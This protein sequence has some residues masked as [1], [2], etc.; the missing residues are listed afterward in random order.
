MSEPGKPPDF[1]NLTENLSQQQAKISALKEL[2]RQSESQHGKNTASAQE[3]VKNIAQRLSSLKTKAA[4]S[5]HRSS[6]DLSEE[7]GITNIEEEEPA[8]LDNSLNMSAQSTSQRARS[9]TPGTEK[10]T[11]LRKQMELNRLK[12]AERETKSKEIEQMVTQLKSKFE[13]SQMSLEKSVELGRSMGDLSSMSLLPQHSQS[14]SDVSHSTRSFNLEN[15][16]IKYLERR[17]REL[18]S[19][20]SENKNLTESERVHRLE[21][22]ILDLEENL[23][24]KE[25]IIEARTKAVSLLSENLTKKKKDVVDSLEDTKQEMFKMQETFLDTETTYKDEVER[26]NR[27][28]SEQS[29]EIQNLTEKCEILEK[30]RYDLTIENSKWNTQL[31]DVQDYSTKI[32]ELNKLNETLQKQISNLESQRYEFVNEEDVDDSAA[33][34]KGQSRADLDEKIKSLEELVQSKSDEIDQ[35]KENLQE[36]STELEVV[37][38]NFSVLQDKYNSLGPKSLFP[39]DEAVDEEAQAEI[40]K[41]KQQLDDSN[42]N[43]IKTKLKVKQLEKQVNSFKKADG[44]KE[45]AKLTE[46]IQTLTQRIAELEEDKSGNQWQEWGNENDSELEKKIKVLETTCQNQTSAIQLLE[47]QKMDIT[48]DLQTAKQELGTSKEN[49]ELQERLKSLEELNE[50]LKRQIQELDE[51]KGSTENKLKQYISENIELTERIDKLSKGSSAESIEMVTLSAKDNEEYQKA[52]GGQKEHHD[53]A[54]PEISQELNDSLRNLREESSELMSKIEL[55]TIERREVLDKLDALSIENQVLVSSIESLRDEKVALEHENEALKEKVEQFERLL[56]ELQ[57]DKEEL[58][59]KASDLN[60]HRS[61][62]Q[63][64]IN[65]L[66][67]EGLESSPHGSPS[68][69]TV[70]DTDTPTESTPAIDR[71][72]C[73]KL[74]KQLDAEIQNLNKNKDK[75]QK[76]KIS[77]KLSENAKSVHA[78][79]TNLLVSYFKSLDD[80]KQLRDDLEK[81]K[82]LMSNV[83]SS[84]KEEEELRS[85]LQKLKETDNELSQRNVECK[86]LQSRLDHLEALDQ[87]TANEEISKLKSKLQELNEDADDKEKL[88]S[89]LQEMIETLTSERDRYEIEVQNQRTLVDDLRKEFDQLCVDVKVNN[90]RLNEKSSEL[91]QLQRE[92]DMRLKTSTNEVEVLKTLVA[93][94]KQLLIDSYQEHELD[95][96]QKIKEINDYQNQIKQMEDELNSLRKLNESNQESYSRDLNSEVVKLKKLLEENNQ[97]LE[98]HKEE[99]LHKQETIDSLNNQII[100]LYKTM[101]ENSSK[102]IEK[103]DEIQY[104]Q[105]ISESSREEIRK[106]HEKLSQGTKTIDDLRAQLSDCSRENELLQQKSAVP[107]N[108][109]QAELRVKK[110]ETDI[111]SLEVKNK[112]QLDKLKKFAANLKKKQ[113]QCTELEAKLAAG[114]NTNTTDAMITNELKAKVIQYE[115][116]LNLIKVE[117]SK[118]NNSLQKS[119]VVSNDELN[120]LRQKIDQYE[121]LTNQNAQEISNLQQQLEDSLA[122]CDQMEEALFNNQSQIQKLETEKMKLSESSNALGEVSQKLASIQRERDEL[123]AKI[124][125]HES[126]DKAEEKKKKDK[127]KAA[128]VQLKHKLAEKKKEVEE[129]TKQLEELKSSSS[130]NTSQSTELLEAQMKEL[131]EMSGKIIEETKSAYEHDIGMLRQQIAELDANNRLLYED[132]HRKVS[133]EGQL[134][135]FEM[136]NARLSEKV[137]KLEETLSS[138]ES[139][140]NSLLREKLS[141]A[142]ELEEKDELIGQKLRETESENF[143]LSETIKELTAERNSLLQKFTSVESQLSNSYEANIEKLTNLEGDN[144]QLRQQIE[145]LQG[146]MKKLQASHEQAVAAKHAEIDEMEADLSSQ[147]QRIEADKKSIQEAL[148]KANDQIVDFQ[149]EVVRLKDNSHTLEQARSDLERELSWLRLQSENYTQ[150]QLENEQLRMQLMQSETETENL[151][152]QNENIQENHAVEI[153]ILKQQI[154]DLEA[155][156]SQVSQNQT[157]DQVMLHNE[158]VKL[159]ELLA[160]KENVIQHKT[161]Q[162][163]M[164]STFDAPVQAVNDPFANLMSQ[165]SAPPQT[166]SDELSVLKEKLQQAEAEIAKLSEAKVMS[167]MELDVQA[168]KLQD[169]LEENRHLRDKVIEMQ[170][171]MDNLIRTNVALEESF[172]RQKHDV[173]EPPVTSSVTAAPAPFGTSML[174]SDEAAQNTAASLFDDPFAMN[175]PPQEVVEEIIKPKKAYLCYDKNSTVETQTDEDWLTDLQEKVT[176]I[177]NLQLHIQSMEQRFVDV[178]AE[179]AMQT[180]S[181]QTHMQRIQELELTLQQQAVT[182]QVLSVAQYFE[183]AQPTPQNVVP[184]SFDQSSS[185]AALEIEDGWGWGATENSEVQQQHSQQQM[186]LLSPRSDL[187][188]RLQEQRDIVDRLEQEKNSLSEELSN[189]RDNSKKMMKKLKEY[190]TKVKDLETRALRKSSSVESNDMDLVIQE[191]LNSQV[192]KLEGKLKDLN[193]EREKEQQE[194]EALAKRVDVL[195]AANERMIEGKERQDNQL[196][197]YQL[198][199]RDLNQKLHNLEEWGEDDEKKNQPVQ[200]SST[201]ENQSE[202]QKVIE[203]LNAQIKD[204]QVDF[205]E[206][207][208]LLDDEKSNSKILEEKVAK[209]STN[210]QE[211]SFKDDEIERL[212]QLLKVNLLQKDHL[213]QEVAI[214]DREIQDLISKLDLLSNES[215]NIRTILDDLSTQIQLKTNEN[216]ELNERLQK[217][218]TNNDDLSRERQLFNDSMEQNY[219]QHANDLE[220][221]LQ[222]LHAEL[223]YKNSQI[224][225]L[226]GKVSSLSIESDQAQSIIDSSNLRDQELITLRS[227]VQELDSLRI[228]IQELETQLQVP[229]SPQSSSEDIN[230]RLQELEKLN[231]NWLLEKSQMEHELQV[232]NDQVL[233][234]LEFEDKMKNTVLE[235][236]SKNIEIQVLK[237]SLLKVQDQ[238]SNSKL[239]DLLTE[240]EKLKHE[241]E[242]LE[243]SMSSSI[244]L[245]NAKW[246]QAVEQ[247]GNEVA[248]SWKSHLEV[249]EAE[250]AEIE[251]SL[252]NQMTQGTSDVTEKTSTSE[253]A[254]KMRSIMESQEV[255][256]V[257]LKEQLAIRSAEYASLSAKVDPYHQLSTSMNVSPIPTTESDRVPRSEL[258]LAL[259]ML[260]QRDM[261]LEEMTMELVRLLEERDQLQLRLS[262]AIRQNE[263]VKRKIA[264][265]DPE[266]SDISKTTTPE[267]TAPSKV[268]FEEDEQ[269]KAKLS[270]LNTVRHNRDKAIQDEREQRFMDNMTMLQRDVANIPPEAAARIVAGSSDQG[271]SPSSVL[272]N[273][274]LGKPDSS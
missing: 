19:N 16:R 83:S 222:T 87:D 273:W 10:I 5:K 115:E 137:V 69:S 186:S 179:L 148:E 74:L 54:D 249:R 144:N 107:V 154:S 96:N 82:V 126:N 123:S 255:E 143:H 129:L 157:D 8:S 55:F 52:L 193:A 183:N 245:L 60:E 45:V 22:R 164:V 270:Q 68:K 178:S 181:N 151:R 106:L 11:L 18:E 252:R 111:Q 246:S 175:I 7:Y 197:M 34:T 90:Q 260:H 76:L 251:A 173:N 191:E 257:S 53:E 244:D 266:S 128:V 101:E 159:K 269:L 153:L 218:A 94:Q 20:A 32:S 274:I 26:L 223:Q 30:S 204:M 1:S 166:S 40:T 108:D 182:Q 121:S 155:M 240:V 198:K 172:E 27:V 132:K 167:N 33:T 152:T 261:R 161:I 78:M 224:Q 125:E 199:I 84:E 239:D 226:N 265:N 63:E 250:F 136:T 31:E 120:E 165:Q 89:K 130:D 6:S 168:N 235:L 141:L 195:T 88:T 192:Q 9:E 124:Q 215:S 241:K 43:M 42:K 13:T 122:K 180:Q 113:A 259:Y 163:Q 177:H 100:D 196:D 17:I 25:S 209:L 231:K 59:K 102:I 267:K 44:N 258:D 23:K 12:M 77:K 243:Q 48:E 73:E 219:R 176:Q 50:D 203:Q 169:L 233:S 119:S 70:S 254:I 142:A 37:N 112:E 81:V 98:E 229:Q 131:Q 262:N 140:K 271:Q 104:L 24:E 234:S 227:Q 118:L 4:K 162:L 147:L 139:E 220:Q 57:T 253:E 67:K 189:L 206:V 213:S 247:R 65:K 109:E 264:L 225:E 208:A 256:I 232:L 41:L 194:K 110:L 46:E 230:K 146:D 216:Q 29:N 2:V 174:F 160:E 58:L 184:S 138:L 103:E 114:G 214:K 35:L 21:G 202:L 201:N 47:E 272:M 145:T 99:L 75:H 117:N 36:K 188:V 200:T 170:S 49:T 205:D 263:D 95:I 61:R 248:N 217:F 51:E 158:N 97:I 135:T 236:D 237:S 185:M 56:S 127:L 14:V 156:R 133:L 211:E 66:V 85:A 171:M 86:E 62:L 80:C 92:F 105:E 238:Q 212:T 72:A 268:A 71:E 79:M 134:E 91:D 93:E 28:I 149:D 207:Q 242:E 64:E 190:Q 38:A 187:E 210:Q 221:Q 228:R 116:Q 39:S 15:E 3:K 150:D